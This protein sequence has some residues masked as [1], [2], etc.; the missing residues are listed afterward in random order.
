MIP[1]NDKINKISA[2]TTIVGPED[3]LISNE[4][5]N[6]INTD[7][8]PPIIDKITICFGLL[9]KLRAIVVGIISI[10]VISNNPTIFIEIA[11]SAASKIVKIAFTL[12]GFM[13]S[14]SASS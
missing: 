1:I 8:R 9:D 11:I 5:Y 3:V 2:T 13:P 6:P 7:K 4:V 10:P 12:S 14:A